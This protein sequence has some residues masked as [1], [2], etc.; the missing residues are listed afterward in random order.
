MFDPTP[1]TAVIGI[2]LNDRRALDDLDTLGPDDFRDER[3]GQ[4]WG[5]IRSQHQSGKP[6]DPTAVA[7]KCRIPG[8]T[9]ADVHS[10]AIEAPVGASAGYYADIVASEAL[11]DRL[12]AT[13]TRIHQLADEADLDQ[14][15]EIAEVARAE[16]DA[17][18]KIG[19]SLAGVIAGEYFSEFMAHVNDPVHLIPTPWVDLDHLI[20]GLRG[21]AVYVVGARPG[22]G[23]SVVGLQLADA[24]QAD[25]GTVLFS[26]L[27]M[28]R[29]EIQKRLIAMHA[30]VPM[31]AF[32]K[33]LDERDL[34]RINANR[35]RLE[36]SR[37]HL[38]DRA[39]VTPGTIRSVARSISRRTR[40]SGI[41]VDYLQ[42]MQGAKNSKM[43][44]HEAV[45]AFSRSLK[46]LAKEMNVPVVVLSQL[47]RNSTQQGAAGPSVADLR[48]SGAIE[49]DADVI[50]LLHQDR[51][52]YPGSLFM[53]VGKNR[54]GAMG[55][56]ELAFEGQY[57][58]ARTMGGGFSG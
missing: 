31:F 43:P 1:E 11:R 8:V 49:Q 4:L 39:S 19:T 12:R 29:D 17:A 28:T 45:A 55:D 44:R 56:F 42:L 53:K 35:E 52:Q 18:A 46:L 3:L 47:N 7:A 10:L 6:H 9:A 2:A 21:G 36:S 16:V 13:G 23:K 26:S 48:E 51:D 14:M 24:M 32:D 41:V 33:P 50:I 30:Q 20:G 40:L 34:A 37:I 15:T 27:E 38:D 22:A 58:R 54:H 5:L 57:A 25:G